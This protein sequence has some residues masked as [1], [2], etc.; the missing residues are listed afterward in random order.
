M[1]SAYPS[2]PIEFR[3]H[4]DMILHIH[5]SGGGGENDM[6]IWSGSNKSYIYITDQGN[7][8]IHKFTTNGTFI[9]MWGEQ[10]EGNGQFLHTHGIDLDSF[11][12]LYVSDRDQPSIQ[13]FTSNGTFIKKWGS[14]GTS[15]GQFIQ[16]W[17]VRVSP[18]DRNTS[19]KK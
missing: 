18:D 10:D 4:P 7:Y 11:G 6:N 3:L 16:P 15:E 9:T 13:K 1:I 2:T 17:D 19:W 12:N 5:K 14:Q 8:R